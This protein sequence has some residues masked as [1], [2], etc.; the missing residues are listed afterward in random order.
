MSIRRVLLT[1]AS[2][3]W[4][5]DLL[6]LFTDS[7]FCSMGLSELVVNNEID[8]AVAHRKPG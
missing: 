8:D 6:Q 4:G 5:I 2:T 7:S 3:T 1:Q